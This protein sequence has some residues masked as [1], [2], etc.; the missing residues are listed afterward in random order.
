MQQNRLFQSFNR[1]RSNSQ[2]KGMTPLFK[3]Q[4]IPE[5]VFPEEEKPYTKVLSNITNLNNIS[6]PL[7]DSPSLKARF[8]GTSSVEPAL[9]KGTFKPEDTIDTL[10]LSENESEFLS[11]DNDVKYETSAVETTTQFTPVQKKLLPQYPQTPDENNLFDFVN[12]MKTL[13]LKKSVL[14]ND[15]LDLQKS[16]DKSKS[17]L[18][19]GKK[20]E[21]KALEFINEFDNNK[22]F[23]EARMKE[24]ED[25]GRFMTAV[26][27]TTKDSS[28]E[29]SIHHEKKK[30]DFENRISQL[31]EA[32]A[33]S[34][35]TIK[36]LNASILDMSKTNDNHELQIV[37]LHEKLQNEIKN[38]SQKSHQVDELQSQNG[39][40]AVIVQQLKHELQGSKS[41][42]TTLLPRFQSCESHMDAITV[43]NYELQKDLAT[44]RQQLE[45]ANT[46]QSSCLT[47][48]NHEIEKSNQFKLES[49]K[50]EEL[51][52]DLKIKLASSNVLCESLNDKIKDLQLN[53]KDSQILSDKFEV[54][55][56]SILKLNA[57]KSSFT[58]ELSDMKIQQ[59]VL[60]DTLNVSN[61]CKSDVDSNKLA[62]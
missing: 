8:Q 56:N 16:L 18:E 6:R 45:N 14:E 12:N 26:V 33:N 31:N 57:D 3:P 1:T 35:S 36:V 62:E 17:E 50:I 52:S 28:L 34:E 44:V 5:N 24:L 60:V 25:F 55:Y 38:L 53:G 21:S 11:F 2:K 39:E 54:L 49:Y 42:Y 4:Q 43:E 10:T 15:K 37:V 41:D 61:T 27:K 46:L 20:L 32:V 7:T 9:I 47:D 30:L 48:L 29:I 58:I 23:I 59:Q 40:L 22:T 13:M 19:S 51:N